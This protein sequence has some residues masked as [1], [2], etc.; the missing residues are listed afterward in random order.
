MGVDSRAVWRDLAWIVLL[1]LFVIAAGYGFRD[2]WPAD[3]PRFAAVARDMALSGDWLFPR[4]GGDLYQDKPP[5]H[6]WLLAAAYSLVG[7]VRGSFLLPSLLASLGTLLLVYDMGRRLH[8]RE[9]G[10]AAALLLGSCVQFVLTT[11]GAQIDATLVFVS[12]L[13]LWALLRHLLL[14]PDWRYCALGAFVAGVGV[15][16]KGVGF[17]P[18]LLL[19]LALGLRRAGGQGLTLPAPGGGGARWWLVPAAFLAAVSLWLVPMLVVVASRGTPELLAYRDEILFQQTVTRYASAWHHVRPWYYFLVEVVPPLWLPLSALVFWL[20]PRWREDWAR[21]R[22]DVL[23]PLL[24]VLCVLLFFSLSPGKRGVYILPALPALALAAAPHLALLLQRPGV[25]R[26]SLAGGAVL[27]LPAWVLG[28]GQLAGVERAREFLAGIELESLWPLWFFIAAGSA[29]W[30]WAWRCRRPVL[31]WPLLLACLTVAW[32]VGV[33]PQ[34]NGVR[35]GSTFMRE[36]Q[37]RVPVGQT[38]GLVAYKEQFLLYLERPIVNFG[39]AR[40]REGEAETRDAARW[41]SAG[42]NRVLLVP[43]SR[44]APCFGPSTRRPGG[45]T[46]REQWWLVSGPVDAACAAQGSLARAIPYAPRPIR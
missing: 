23:L 32:G 31:A 36:V 19:P 41:L 27:L 13:A 30:L 33:A 22:A 7:S 18:L 38:L 12:T 11:R 29:G 25:G 43:E 37:A 34:I 35:T 3:E 14:G 17:L 45:I 20:L 1:F 2:P 39:H 15:I 28:V 46:S 44:L 42:A 6:F 21:R 4:A 40:W 8:G 10:L 5:V 9:A 16:T 26:L 24:W